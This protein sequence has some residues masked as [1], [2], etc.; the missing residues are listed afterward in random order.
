MRVQIDIEALV[1]P[2]VIDPDPTYKVELITDRI[3]Y[4]EREPVQFRLFARKDGYL[5]IFNIKNDT[6]NVLF[7]NEMH[8]LLSIAFQYK[9]SSVAF[10]YCQYV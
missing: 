6:L 2:Q 10:S 8:F 9:L 4:N 1:A 3:V 5:T 7:P